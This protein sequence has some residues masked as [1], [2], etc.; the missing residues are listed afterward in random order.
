M[1]EFLDRINTINGIAQKEVSAFKIMLI[2]LILS[3]NSFH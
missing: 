2:V 1:T 3:K